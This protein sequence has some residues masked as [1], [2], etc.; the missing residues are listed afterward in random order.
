MADDSLYKPQKEELLVDV[1]NHSFYTVIKDSMNSILSRTYWYPTLKAFNKKLDE[2]MYAKHTNK[3]EALIEIL[4]HLDEILLNSEHDVMKIIKKRKKD[5]KQT[6]VS[7]AGNNFQ[8]LIAHSLMA[9]VIARNLPPINIVLKPK[10][11]VIA[12]KYTT[13]KI[14]GETQKPDMDIL[15]YQDKPKTPIIICSCKTSLRERAGQTY[16]WKLLVDLATADP[17]HLKKYPDCPI[18]KYEIEYQSDRKIYML[19]ITADLYN[20]V[21]QPQ[22]RGMFMFFDKAFIANNK[23]RKLPLNVQPL[24]KII[25]YLQAIYHN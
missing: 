5:V 3:K 20:E 1:K 23:G 8:A 9:N 4:N 13:I 25:E 2:I 18:N 16:R 19:M 10:E 17:E 24:S 7:V 15:I 21:S 6:R 22:Q 11:H 14:N 12:N